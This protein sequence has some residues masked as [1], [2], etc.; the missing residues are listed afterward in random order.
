MWFQTVVGSWMRISLQHGREA[1]GGIFGQWLIQGEKSGP[2]E[3]HQ[4]HPQLL[5]PDER[6]LDIGLKRTQTEELE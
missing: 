5:Y 1:S 6:L 3:H 4:G 2:Y